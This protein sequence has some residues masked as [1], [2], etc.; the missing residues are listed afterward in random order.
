MSAARREQAHKVVEALG[1]WISAS[2]DQR[3]ID[4]KETPEGTWE[5]TLQEN[6]RARGSTALDALSQ[7]ATAAAMESESHG[8][9]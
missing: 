6:R 5:A 3:S 4:L 8:V 9:G 1:A 2:P 7:V